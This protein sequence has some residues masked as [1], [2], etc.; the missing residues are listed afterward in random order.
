MNKIDV[1]NERANVGRRGFPSSVMISAGICKLG[2][3][4]IHFVNP[5]VKVNRQYYCHDLLPQLLPE[6][7]ALLSNGDYIFMQDGARS[8]TS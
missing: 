2:K 5:G 7:E 4:S 1:S 3:T 6:M 8:H